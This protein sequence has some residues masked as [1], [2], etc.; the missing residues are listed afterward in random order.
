MWCRLGSLPWPLPNALRAL[1][2]QVV[3]QVALSLSE[4]MIRIYRKLAESSASQNASAAVR[5]AVLRVDGLLEEHFVAPAARHAEAL[6]R[7]VM[8]T[9][10]SRQDPLFARVMGHEGAPAT[11][12]DDVMER[13]AAPQVLNAGI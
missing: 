12:D 1:F 11:A 5:E 9:S 3:F 2:C 8:R 7:T 6:S 13:V 10:L 4:L